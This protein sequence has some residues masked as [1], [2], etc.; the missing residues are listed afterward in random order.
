[1]RL[2]ITWPATPLT[3][4]AATLVIGGCATG[5]GSQ[6]CPDGED[7]GGDGDCHPVCGPGDTCG[8]CQ[9]CDEGLCYDLA[10]CS[11]LC[12]NGQ[13][14]TADGEECDDSNTVTEHC[15]YGE[16]SCIVCDA[17]CLEAAGVTHLCGDSTTDATAGE[18][19][20]DGNLVTERCPYGQ[21]GCTVCDDTC[22]EVIGEASSCGNGVVDTDDAEV[23]DDGN[24]IGGDGCSDQCAIE[25]GWSCDTV[26]APSV[27]IPIPD[28]PVIDGEVSAGHDS[29]TWTWTMP[30]N[31]DHF[32][33]RIDAAAYVDTNSQEQTATG[34]APGAHTIEVTACNS[35]GVCST[36]ASFTTTIEYFGQQY[37]PA[38]QGV[39]RPNL[40][41]SA[42]G[43]VVP[44]SCHNCYNGPENQVY[45]T[46]GANAKIDNALGREADLIELDIADAGGTLCVNHGDLASCA[47]NP[48]LQDLL[49][50]PVLAAADALLFVEIKEGNQA[51]DAFALSLLGLLDA[52]RAYVKNGRPIYLRAFSGSLFYLQAIQNRLA[53]FPMIASYVRFSVL[54]GRD[55]TAA[56]STFGANIMADV[57]GNGFDM[58]ELDYRNRNLAGLTKLAQANDLAVGLYTIPGDFGEVFLATHRENVDQLTAE[59]RV[60]QARAVVEETNTFAYIDAS[61]CQSA[62]DTT[63]TVYRN[64]TGTPSSSTQPV[65]RAPTGTLYGTP[66]LHYDGQ[67]EDRYGCSL[68][69]RSNQSLL[70]RALPLGTPSVSGAMGY[71]VSAV[72]NFDLLSGFS[73]TQAIVNSSQTGGF[74]LEVNG[75]GT[76]VNIRFG[77]YVNGAYRFHTYD[78][79]ATGL[80]G[81]LAS[82]NGTDGYLVTGAYDGDGGVYLFIDNV[83]N[84]SGGSYSGGVTNSNQPALVGGDPQ[85]ADALTARFFFD[86]FIQRAAVLYWGSHDF[87]GSLEND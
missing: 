5:T 42:I 53:D 43:N 24:G 51:A 1:M 6:Q 62:A 29:P 79:A 68:D 31:T 35:Q 7:R 14:D 84:G 25:G 34:L 49:D 36:A 16:N 50:N 11:S 76:T 66:A 37:P 83:H 52:N 59:Y 13:V 3:L 38:W 64:T 12:G 86:G 60:D 69:T 22:H 85:P 73:G 87:T 67:G 57:A 19:C 70:S 77:V 78:V 72:V 47:S 32:Q 18:E 33:S 15:T 80:G 65:D 61:G 30:A 44:I 56:V 71:L 20:D 28:P 48:T 9:E 75:N 27:C 46:A 82:L 58:V 74:A 39:Q 4:L 54:Y 41:T 8:D 26:A 81:T 2:T 45:T 63:V 55:A 17:D 40:T 10:S 23:C 21:N